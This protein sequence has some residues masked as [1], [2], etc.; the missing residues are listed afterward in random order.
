MKRI[1]VTG[2]GAIASVG[3]NKDAVFNAFIAGQSG[4]APIESF[5][6]SAYKCKTGG[7]VSGLAQLQPLSALN[8]KHVDRASQLL[9]AVS[10]EAIADAGLDVTQESSHSISL[11]TGTTLGG[12]V[13]GEKFYREII[14]DPSKIKPARLLHAS[15]NA[16]NDYTMAYFGLRGHSVVISTACS[17]STH[18][19]GYGSDL[20]QAGLANVV[21]A[22]GFEPMSELTFSG[23]GILRALTNEKV[24]PF[25]GKRSGLALGEGAAM[26]LLEDLE[27]ARKRG[28][29]IYAELVGYGSSSDAYHMTGPHPQGEGA[30][31]AM[32]MA[33]ADAGVR[34]QDVSYINAHG[35]ATPANDAAETAA[36][37][38]VFGADA[39]DVPISSTKSMV[40]HL[41]GAAGAIEA[42]ASVMT[43]AN[44]VIPPTINYENPDPKCDL[45]CTP[46]QARELPVNIAMSNSFGFGGNNGVVLFSKFKD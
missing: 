27:H 21:L 43:V 39:L 16:A 15:P 12:M 17:A 37:K 25:D 14:V 24:R 28:A 36:I 44:D 6:T 40:G 13:S 11:V 32:R 34:P 31:R 30:G 42:V 18:A 22:G 45:N 26:V 1:V 5:D 4:I 46:N 9:L 2:L 3:N 10:Y 7:E 41:L 38:G 20:I 23:F 8:T 19:L 33:L 35:T 29:R